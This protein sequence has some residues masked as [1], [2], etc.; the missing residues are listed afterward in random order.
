M[1]LQ[2]P[3]KQGEVSRSCFR[4]LTS[5]LTKFEPFKS[6]SWNEIDEL[7]ALNTLRA[8]ENNQ[9]QHH[10]GNLCG[11]LVV[12]VAVHRETAP[13]HFTLIESRSISNYY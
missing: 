8:K 5:F 13:V 10:R 2:Y 11:L 12:A 1:N 4:Q 7:S 3:Q 6:F 9:Y